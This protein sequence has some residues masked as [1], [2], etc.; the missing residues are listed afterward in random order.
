MEIK[1]SNFELDKSIFEKYEIIGL[2][3]INS[4]FIYNRIYDL[5]EVEFTENT[6]VNNK[7]NAGLIWG[8][9][10]ASAGVLVVGGIAFGIAIAKRRRK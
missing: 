5:K 4:N 7:N 2:I 9:A 6:K 1:Y 10:G 8:I 3:D